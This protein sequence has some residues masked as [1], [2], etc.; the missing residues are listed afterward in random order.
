M[1]KAEL[2]VC[3]AFRS[4]RR[5]RQGFDESLLND[6]IKRGLMPAATLIGRDGRR[7][8]YGYDWKAYRRGL[9]I[10]RL[11]SR[12]V[13]GYDAVKLQLFRCGYSLPA[14]DAR[15][16]LWPEYKARAATLMAPIR[17]RYID[18]ERTIDGR[19]RAS[20]LASMGELDPDLDAAGFRL[21]DDTYI[22]GLRLAKG[23]TL[24]L[25]TEKPR[26]GAAMAVWGD[27]IS[28]AKFAMSAVNMLAGMLLIGSAGGRDNVGPVDYVEKFL[29]NS[30]DRSLEAARDLLASAQIAVSRLGDIGRFLGFQN[31]TLAT[32]R[33]WWKA[34]NAARDPNWTPAMFFFALV[35]ATKFRIAIRP[36]EMIE[37]LD[38]I[39]NS[40]FNFWS[41]FRKMPASQRLQLEH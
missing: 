11:R 29:A 5:Y 38:K 1:T 18:G 31:I 34:G 28:W 32:H 10:A 20:L 3:L 13:V 23:G 40:R 41:I 2:V 7:P 12:G 30:D 6:L 8:I 21:P 17:S 26:T 22:Q 35:M 24:N 39:Q 36:V 19:H 9:Q 14:Y 15:S 16:A 33:A 37:I 25:A 4:Q 27:R